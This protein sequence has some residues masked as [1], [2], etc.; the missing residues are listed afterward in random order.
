[1]INHEH[2]WEVIWIEGGWK[3]L[4]IENYVNSEQ[5]WMSKVKRISADFSRKS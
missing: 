4:E 5:E 1:M 3:C 2:I